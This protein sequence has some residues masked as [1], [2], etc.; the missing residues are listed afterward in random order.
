MFSEIVLSHLKVHVI[1]FIF[2]AGVLTLQPTERF[3]YEE[4]SIYTFT[5]SVK[6]QYLVGLEKKQL[7][8]NITNVNEPPSISLLQD[9]VTFDEDTV[10]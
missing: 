8:L 10:I 1:L 7:T 9:I 4:R 5:F 2:S 6:D 3:N